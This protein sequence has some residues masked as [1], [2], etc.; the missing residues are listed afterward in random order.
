MKYAF[1]G[2]RTVSKE[3]RFDENAGKNVGYEITENV[4]GMTLREYYAGQALVGL[5]VDKPDNMRA[6]SFAEVQKVVAHAAVAYADALIAELEENHEYPL[7][8]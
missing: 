8:N 2:K 3:V 7:E 1:P 5:L 4:S 6:Q